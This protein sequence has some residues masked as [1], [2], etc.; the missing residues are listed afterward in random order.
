[1]AAFG[2]LAA[3]IAMQNP[4]SLILLAL[5]SVLLIAAYRAYA[6]AREQQN[7][8]RCCTRSPRCSTPA[9]TPRPR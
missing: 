9:T 5:P 1:M 2:L 8:L 3:Q 7:N 6:K 4:A